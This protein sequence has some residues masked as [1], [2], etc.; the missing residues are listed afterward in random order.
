MKFMKINI[1]TQLASS[2]LFAMCRNKTHIKSI[3]TEAPDR[4]NKLKIEYIP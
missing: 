2:V 1:G 4:V 3:I